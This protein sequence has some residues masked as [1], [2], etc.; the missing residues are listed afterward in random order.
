MTQLRYNHPLSCT[1]SASLAHLA[2]NFQHI[3]APAP[4]PAYP[5]HPA[6]CSTHPPSPYQL[7]RTA[8]PPSTHPPQTPPWP[9]TNETQ[10]PSPAC[11][12]FPTEPPPIQF[13]LTAGHLGH[14]D[15]GPCLPR[16]W[17]TP[18]N[19]CVSSSHGSSSCANG[20]L[21]SAGTEDDTGCVAAM[22][23]MVVGKG[24]G[25]HAPHAPHHMTLYPPD[26]HG[27]HLPQQQQQQQQQQLH[28]GCQ[29]CAQSFSIA[30]SQ[31]YGSCLP[32]A[33]PTPFEQLPA[34]VLCDLLT[35]NSVAA[36]EVSIFDAVC[37]WAAA[38]GWGAGGVPWHDS[39]GG[40]EAAGGGGVCDGRGSGIRAG[41][42]GEHAPQWKQLGGNTGDSVLSSGTAGSRSIGGVHRM[43]D[44]AEMTC[45]SSLSQQTPT[46]PP[47]MAPASQVQPPS[48]P[49]G[50][51]SA[52]TRVV[53]D[54]SDVLHV[55]SLVRFPLMKPQV[56][57]R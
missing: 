21:S 29:G 52:P 26:L 36:P 24:D 16:C 39:S 30:S 2:A 17:P 28:L 12:A 55:L 48:H 42:G 9:S 8:Y 43:D 37:R 49:S 45:L 6:T 10:S 47:L 53:H 4:S 56:G 40:G 27:S 54:P 50:M 46:A 44:E 14:G 19:G 25:P 38:G 5:P 18:I 1:R 23:G 15:C 57:A 41:T 11:T 3:A 31:P 51:S 13:D 35:L 20:T 7:P 32:H 22:Q 33:L 34:S